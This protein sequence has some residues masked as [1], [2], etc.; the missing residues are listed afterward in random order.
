M[1]ELTHEDIEFFKN[2]GYLIK[3]EVLNP[4]LMERARCRLWEGAPE[5]RVR[6]NPDTWVGPFKPEEENEE[7]SNR[8]KGFRWNYREPGGED[9]M[10]KLLATDP[11]V[12]HMAEQFL[13][14]G[15]LVE[16]A[17]VRGIYCTL[18]Y[19][20]VPK[21]VDWMSCGRASVPSR[22]RWLH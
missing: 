9:W 5:G 4:E 7:N 13:G 16:P 18:P 10:V 12:W 6:E 17:R 11:N 8:R 19:G 21:K 3:R 14:E 15:N 20:D 1:V 2:E 22:C